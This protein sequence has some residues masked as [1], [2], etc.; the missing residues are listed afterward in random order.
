M[1][2][3]PSILGRL[4]AGFLSVLRD[5]VIGLAVMVHDASSCREFRRD[6]AGLT[7]LAYA[8]GAA[9]ILVPLA[10]LL[11]EFGSAAEQSARDTIEPAL[12]P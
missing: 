10:I 3:G 8:L 6:D 7:I 11:W 12:N 2:G 5:G 1:T 4:K 9:L